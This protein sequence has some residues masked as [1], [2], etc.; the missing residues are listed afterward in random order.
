MIEEGEAAGDRNRGSTKGRRASAREPRDRA[1][2][3]VTRAVAAL[4]G[5]RAVEI[6]ERKGLGHPDSIC[7]AVA[8]EFSLA[9]ARFYLEQTGAILH[10]N[11]D[12]TLLAAGASRPRFGGGAVLEPMRLFLAGRASPARDGTSAPV[13]EIAEQAARGWI[14]RNLRAVDSRNHVVVSNLVRPGSVELVDLFD[15]QRESRIPLANDTSCGV[16][17]APLSETERIVL[18]VERHLTSDASHA[19]APA[20]G[21]DVKVMA[22]RQGEAVRLT[23]A[24]AMIDSA[25]RDSADY[26][27]AKRQARELALEAA[28]RVSSL[29]VSAAVNAAD[30]PDSDRIYLTVTGTSAEA[31]DDGQAGRG[32]R[33]NGLIAPGRPMTMESVA[34]KNPVNHVGKLYNLVAGLASHRLVEALPD[35]SAAECRLVSRIGAPID[36][37]DLVEVQ[38][39]GADPESDRELARAA[40]AIVDEELDRL[41]RLAEELV[42]G[43]LAVGRWPLRG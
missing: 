9:L 21:E 31:G 30:D 12:K 25:L 35:V 37:P 11:V 3:A 23:I 17:Y 42:S 2:F 29:D 34:G 18:A 15:R 22:V 20:L 19:I 24:C 10:H 1:G 16:G 43:A 27:K 7:D 33:S 40:T 6:V 5:E 14:E 8:E 26:A 13:T 4:P 36:E 28:G 41:P 39:S 32:N 38:L